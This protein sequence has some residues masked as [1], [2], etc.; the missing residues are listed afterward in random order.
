ME[1][2]TRHECCR[3]SFL[4]FFQLFFTNTKISSALQHD[5]CH[6]YVLPLKFNC[7][8]IF[9]W[10]A[11][12]FSKGIWDK[13][14]VFLVQCL[15][16]ISIGIKLITNYIIIFRHWYFISWE[17]KKVYKGCQLAPVNLKFQGYLLAI[18]FFFNIFIEV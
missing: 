11:L 17:K 2:Q 5:E 12:E 3:L 18:F 8:R 9:Y 16:T 4:D 10:D 13:N 15:L 14:L 1:H 7:S 6:T